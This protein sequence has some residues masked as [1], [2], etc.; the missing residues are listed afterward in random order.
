MSSEQ[1]FRRWALPLCAVLVVPFFLKITRNGITLGDPLV[2]QGGGQTFPFSLIIVALVVGWAGIAGARPRWSRSA[3][4]IVG[5]TALN[6]V[7]MIIG[8][9]SSPRLE[10]VLFCVQTILPVLA[11][12]AGRVTVRTEEDTRR[13]FFWWVIALGV[14]IWAV[15]VQSLI[16]L[17]PARTLIAGLDWY[18]WK[19]PIYSFYDYVPTGVAA[20]YG[21]GLALVLTTDQWTFRVR[22]AYILLT[23]MFAAVF[24]MH[25]KGGM[26]TILAA[27]TFCCVASIATGRGMIRAVLVAAPHLVIAAAILFSGSSQAAVNIGSTVQT[28]SRPLI[29]AVGS[30]QRGSASDPQPSATAKTAS[31]ASVVSRVANLRA[32]METVMADPLFGAQY[33]AQS[34]SQGIY[35]ISN[36]HNQ[37]LTYAVRAGLVALLAFMWLLGHIGRLVWWTFRN[38]AT[39]GIQSVSCGLIAAL[40][41]VAFV[42]N[43]LQD[44][45]IQPYTAVV[46]WFLL[47]T[48]ENLA[49]RNDT[50]L[51]RRTEAT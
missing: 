32:S 22:F 49:V 51:L 23:G 31:D 47:A 15:G 41:A 35:R 8:L 45:F 20:V 19:I 38:P 42:S 30:R 29:V 11:F 10:N 34:Q 13:L 21:L 43:L 39:P 24:V 26:L 16:T 46:L 1:H 37:Y 4:I 17:G 5:F 33:K 12:V 44:N 25:S 7:A 18:L 40:A 48:A 50:L 2:P 27:L 28:F 3:A 36:P 9:V 14:S 6:V